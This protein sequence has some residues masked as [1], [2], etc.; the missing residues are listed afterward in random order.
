[1]FLCIPLIRLCLFTK[2]R[3]LLNVHLLGL[4]MHSPET[5]TELGMLRKCV[6]LRFLP[7][8]AVFHQQKTEM[9]LWKT[10]LWHVSV[11]WARRDVGL[12]QVLC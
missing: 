2:V 8:R 5:D 6:L 12:C 10:E 3:S 7:R 4:Q 11:L 9:H 1:M